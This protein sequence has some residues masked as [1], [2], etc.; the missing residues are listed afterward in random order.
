[1]QNSSESAGKKQE[2]VSRKPDSKCT[3]ERIAWNQ[4]NDWPDLS[5]QQKLIAYEWVGTMHNISDTAKAVGLPMSRVQSALR[6]PWIR[7]FV[8]HLESELKFVSI[9]SREWLEMEWLD[10]YRKLTGD[11]PVPMVDTHGV[12]YSARKYH[13]NE[14]VNALKE[15]G[16]IVEAYP[17]DDR[18]GSNSSG[19]V[20][21]IDLRALGIEEKPPIEITE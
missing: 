9:L 3:P 20:V 19:T 6:T 4:E 11:I 5:S 1:M 12:E 14:V 15:I 21:N 2:L 17:K 16:K 7:A 8:D 10:Q 18:H 13:S